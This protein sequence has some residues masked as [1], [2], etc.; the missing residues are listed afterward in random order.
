MPKPTPTSVLSLDV[1]SKRI[2]L[3]GCDP[4]GI[5]VKPLPPLARSS[6][7][8]DLERLR[9]ICKDRNV[10]GLIIGNPLDEKGNTTQ[11][12]KDCEKYGTQIAIALE[13]PIAWVNEHS[14]S[15]EASEIFNLKGDKTGKL[16]SAAAFLLL[17][18]WLEEG[19]ELKPV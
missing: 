10:K 19:P 4:L 9:L 12:S 17:K 1:G 3:A 6:I 14:S 18:Q 8:N 15:W 2:G 7:K 11:Q 16:D 13:L 5:T